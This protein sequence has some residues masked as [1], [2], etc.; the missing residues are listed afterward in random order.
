MLEKNTFVEKDVLPTAIVVCC[1]DNDAHGCCQPGVM[2]TPREQLET[3]FRVRFYQSQPGSG[4]DL[5]D[6]SI[7]SSYSEIIMRQLQNVVVLK[8]HPDNIIILHHHDCAAYAQHLNGCSPQQ[9]MEFH[10]QEMKRL[11][12]RL[13]QWLPEYQA[14]GK[15]LLFYLHNDGLVLPVTEAANE[16]YQRNL[17][18]QS[19]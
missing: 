18:Q 19:A 14:P 1:G 15:V 7:A 17:Q 8:E 6:A 10:I 5:I 4:K 9:H 2:K 11:Q 12:E 16:H 13:E 3:M